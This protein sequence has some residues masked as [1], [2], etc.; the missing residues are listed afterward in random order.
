MRAFVSASC[1]TRTSASPAAGGSGRG[2]PPTWKR[3]A[4]LSAPRVG[5]LFGDVDGFVAQH[6]DRA[7][8][9][10]QS[11]AHQ[12]AGTAAAASRTSRRVRAVV[13]EAAQ[14]LHL[15]RQGAQRVRE[16]VVH[17]AGDP[18]A[19][20]EHLGAFVLDL[21]ALLGQRQLGLLPDPLLTLARPIP[22]TS[23]AAAPLAAL[24]ITAAEWPVTATAIG[25]GDDA[26][27]GHCG[28]GLMSS[29]LAAHMPATPITATPIG[30]STTSAPPLAASTATATML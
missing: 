26:G 11:F 30:C 7:T 27:R 25:G 22:T 18:V 4:S 14:R 28:R 5:E 3:R 24:P 8:G 12:A 1:A 10:L 20:G 15:H 13:D 9:L 29:R 23:P 2:S 21:G 6:P 19:F 16:Y 17:L